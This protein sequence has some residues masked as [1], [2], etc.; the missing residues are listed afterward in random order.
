MKK[1]IV[2]VVAS[3]SLLVGGAVGASVTT[4]GNS[5]EGLK[6]NYT[7]Q[8]ATFKEDFQLYDL[9]AYEE[10]KVAQLEGE[11]AK[12]FEEQKAAYKAN[13]VANVDVQYENAKADVFAH[14]DELFAN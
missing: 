6:V 7:E 2:A 14:I 8:A 10:E 12:H 11:A 3:V 5:A 9:R 13:S 4:L 1:R